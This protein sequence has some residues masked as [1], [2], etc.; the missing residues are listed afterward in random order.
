MTV[1]GFILSQFMPFQQPSVAATA[2]MV[3]FGAGGVATTALMVWQGIKT[4]R[5][6]EQAR[7]RSDALEIL[8]GQVS[9]LRDEVKLLRADL[10]AEKIERGEVTKQLL[11]A[12]G[13]LAAAREMVGRLKLQRDDRERE[14]SRTAKL[15]KLYRD[16]ATL[17][18]S[19]FP[20]QYGLVTDELRRRNATSD[21]EQERKRQ[22]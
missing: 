2:L 22:S 14:L 12:T 8:K 6:E 18:K 5:L 13:Q 7:N 17:T 15:L 11:D 21:A 9:D 10:A 20:E 4:K 3:L 16:L 1:P 19:M